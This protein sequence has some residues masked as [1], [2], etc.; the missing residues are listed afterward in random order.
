MQRL[1]PTH[2]FRACPPSVGCTFSVP[3]TRHGSRPISRICALAT[4]RWRRRTMSSAPSNV[5]AVLMPAGRQATLY[6]DL[7][8]TTPEYD[9][10][11][12]AAFQQGL[13]RR[14]HRDLSPGAA[15]LLWLPV[16]HGVLAQSPIQLPRHHILVPTRLPQP[17]AEAEIVVFFRV[18]DALEDRTMFLLMLR[19]G[20]RVSEVSHVRWRRSIWSRGPCA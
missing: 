17:M 10:W 7:T 2:P 6:Q 4:M 3:R 18:I 13:A 20:L 15:G 19:C 1:Q 8:Q 11:I 5:S 9:A 16:H 12:A 14:D